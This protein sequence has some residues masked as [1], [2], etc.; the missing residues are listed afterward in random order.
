LTPIR[1]RVVTEIE[2]WNPVDGS[3]CSSE[4]VDYADNLFGREPLVH[5]HDYWLVEG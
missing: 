1:E 2:S 5:T 3:S 4:S